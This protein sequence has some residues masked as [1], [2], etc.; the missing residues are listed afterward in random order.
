MIVLQVVLVLVLVPLFDHH[1]VGSFPIS[2]PS[3]RLPHAPCPLACALM[4][5]IDYL[6][7]SGNSTLCNCIYVRNPQMGHLIT[8]MS[9]EQ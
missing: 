7:V 9:L 2:Y 8:L 1:R 5:G 3:P 4:D 6:L